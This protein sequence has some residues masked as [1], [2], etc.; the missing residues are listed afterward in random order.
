MPAAG[1]EPA[2]FSVTGLKSVALTTR[3]N[4]LYA[5]PNALRTLG[6]E[7]RANPW[8]GSMLPLHHVRFYSIFSSLNNFKIKMFI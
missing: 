7:P 3:P 4:W 6:I 5:F 2:H 1:I 8:K